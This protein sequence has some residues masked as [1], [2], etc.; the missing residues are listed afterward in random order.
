MHG[1]N[2]MY[3]RT[4]TG[5][6]WYLIDFGMSTMVLHKRQLNK[7]S[8]GA[9]S[10]YSDGAVGKDGHDVRLMVLSIIDNHSKE[11][12]KLLKQELF[13]ELDDL[14][15]AILQQ[16]DEN[17]VP[18]KQYDWHRGYRHAFKNVETLVTE[19][20]NFLE[21]VVVKYEKMYNF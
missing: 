12:Q 5:Y 20:R 21:Q 3:K 9:Y 18:W 14:N 1:G 2:I 4:K 7:Y 6:D 8:V 10:P 13:T 16:F 17:L 19:P 11:L 15:M